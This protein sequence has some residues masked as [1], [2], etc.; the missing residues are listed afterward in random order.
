M[1][2][3][4]FSCG[5]FSDLAARTAV[6]SRAL[7]SG[8]PAAAAKDCGLDILLRH[9]FRFSSQN[10]CAQPGIAVRVAAALGGD[11]D[12]LEQAGEYLAALGIERALLVLNCGPF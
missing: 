12:F 10:G 1:A 2:R 8:L 9:F 11:C 5:M 6:R 3:L 7:L 4:I